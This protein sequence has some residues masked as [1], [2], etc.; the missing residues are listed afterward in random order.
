[1]RSDTV[2]YAWSV[3]G[4]VLSLSILGSTAE[5]QI[6]GTGEPVQ[7]TIDDSATISLDVAERPLG[8]V[9]RLIH[10][11]SGANILLA[12]G[13]DARVTIAFTGVPWREALGLVAE[14][15]GCIVNETKGR[16]YRV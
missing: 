4:A 12:P 9:L 5:A 3:L 10:D 14:N 1:M 8:D 16:I 2:R 15:A 11:R 13:V 6:F 7:S